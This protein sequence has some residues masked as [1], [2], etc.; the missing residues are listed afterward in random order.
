MTI[1][2]QN[3]EVVRTKPSLTDRI[4]RGERENSGIISG[5]VG[6]RLE[7]KE[8]DV[9][10]IKRKFKNLNRLDE[11]EETIERGIITAPLTKAVKK[12]Q[13]EKDLKQDGLIYPK[14]ETEKALEEED[15]FLKKRVYDEMKKRNINSGDRQAIKEKPLSSM[16]FL[17]SARS[18]Q[19]TTREEF[20]DKK[21]LGDNDA[22]AFRHALWNYL[23]TKMMGEK[24]A[25]HFADGHENIPNNPKGSKEM[26]L[27]NNAVGRALAKDP[28]NKNK[29]DIDVIL[30]ALKKGQLQIK[31]KQE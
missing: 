6:N 9:R 19:N 25:K 23:M 26:D 1:I 30:E 21:S 12:F 28:K 17:L 10:L 5:P 22:D 20:S 15:V 24:N 31:P 16:L 29:K 7:N 2:E 27:F 14:G 13:K 11:D 3:E 4:L 8:S 18:V